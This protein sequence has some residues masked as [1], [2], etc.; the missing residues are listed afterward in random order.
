MAH[1]FN[2]DT[3]FKI[4]LP[5]AFKLCTDNVAQVRKAAAEKIYSLF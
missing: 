5:I 3:I 1:I 4:I 2:P